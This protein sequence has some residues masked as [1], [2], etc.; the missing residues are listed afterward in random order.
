M[1]GLRIH[2]ID[3]GR[4]DV[5][6]SYCVLVIFMKMGQKRRSM[7]LMILNGFMELLYLVGLSRTFVLD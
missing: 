4:C 6:L 1:L 7:I 5:W 2:E 3:C